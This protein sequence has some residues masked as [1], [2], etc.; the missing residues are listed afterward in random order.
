MRHELLAACENGHDPQARR[1]AESFSAGHG[2]GG[3][4]PMKSLLILALM[5]VIGLL[6]F[7]YL[8]TGELKLLPGSSMGG[9]EQELNR[10]QGEF[11]NAAR[12]YRQAQKSVAVS[13]VDATDAAS[14]ALAEVDGIEDEVRQ[15]AK[16]ASTPELKAAADKL[17]KEIA[18]Y[19][20]DVQ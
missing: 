3:K 18:Q 8:T 5:V 20:L 9:S 17:L 16:K 4:P 15:F 2:D 19:K 13:G 14:S 12:E 11:R 6:T 1:V 10:L 7:N